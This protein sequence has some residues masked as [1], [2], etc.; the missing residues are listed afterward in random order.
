MDTD[1]S[2]DA[3][4]PPTLDPRR[5]IAFAVVLAAG[6]MDLLDVTIV[7]VAAPSIQTDL[8]AEYSHIEWIIAAYVLAFAAVLITGGRLGDIYGRKRIFLIGM[9]GFILAS[10][11]C[12]L[13]SDP[14]MLITSRFVQGAMAGLMV[15]QIL[16][17]IR[18]TFPEHERAKAIAVY[19]GVGGSASAV[20]LS[21]GGLLVQWDVFDLAWRPIFLVNIPVGIAALVAASVVMRDSRSAT[22]PRLDLVGMVLAISAV[23]LLAYPLTEGRQL[24]WPAWTFAMM[25]AAA[26]VFGLFVAYERRRA[27]T[28]GSP[29]IDLELFRSRP[30]AVG[31]ASWLLFW[32]GLGGFFLVWTLF[33]QAGLGWSPMRAGLTAVCFAVGAGTGVGVGVGVLAPRFGRRALIA[34]GLVNAGGFGLYGGMA[35]HYGASITSWQMVIPLIIIGIGF[36]MV[37]APTIDLL[38]GQ[39]PAREAGSASGLLNTGQQLGTALGVALVGVV[40]FGQLDHD[41]ARGVEAVAPQVRAELGTM[42][43][44]QPAQDEILANFLACVQDRSAEVDPT[45]VPDSCRSGSA[46]GNA[47]VTHVLTRAGVEANAVNFANTFEYTLWYGIAILA[48]MCLGFFALPKDAR[49]KQHELDTE[50]TDLTPA[51][52]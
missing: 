5:W 34:G 8:R 30:F 51:G 43:L 11:A 17:I 4:A 47:G 15:P 14:T 33:M 12:G 23:L 48:L 27:R 24:D 16:A 32:I 40:F 45:V 37:V 9:T 41:S 6:F 46:P 22:P 2:P 38:L 19:S 13:S 26:V 52:V 39:V 42:G 3:D 18:A 10:A 35:A 36:G 31:L 28:G 50:S 21:L 29:L 44:P 1:I 25:G 49:L 20:G 7:N